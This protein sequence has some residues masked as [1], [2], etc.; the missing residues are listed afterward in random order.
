MPATL[1]GRGLTVSFGDHLVLDRIEVAIAARAR[2]GVVGPN[3]TGKTT[4]LPVLAGALAPDTGTVS[5]APSPAPGPGAPA[6]SRGPRR[7]GPSATCHRNGNA[8]PARRCARSWV[9]A[10]GSRPR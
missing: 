7:R 4:L 9:P 8:E 3:G 6:R 1:L 5:L 2:I 10:P